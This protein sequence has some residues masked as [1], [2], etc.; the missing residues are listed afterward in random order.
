MP[1]PSH[2]S[3]FYHPHNSVWGVEIMKLLFKKSSP[4]PCYLVPLRP[5]NILYICVK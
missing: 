2:S 3:P 5:K 4:L 1:R